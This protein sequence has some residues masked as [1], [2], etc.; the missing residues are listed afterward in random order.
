V[1]DELPD[2]QLDPEF[3]VPHARGAL[4]RTPKELRVRF[5]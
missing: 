1:L 2:V 3:P 4:M 5:G